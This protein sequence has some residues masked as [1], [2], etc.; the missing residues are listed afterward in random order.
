MSEIS[1]DKKERVTVVTRN[2]EISSDS[3]SLREKIPLG[4]KSRFFMETERPD[5][6]SDSSCFSWN[7]P[8][9]TTTAR[10]LAS[11]LPEYNFVE[12][13]SLTVR[14]VENGAKFV[15]GGLPKIELICSP[16]PCIIVAH[17]PFRSTLTSRRVL[18]LLV[19][20]SAQHALS[21]A[22]LFIECGLWEGAVCKLEI[23]RPSGGLLAR[24][25]RDVWFVASCFHGKTF[26]LFR[27]FSLRLF[28]SSTIPHIASNGCNCIML[29]SFLR[30][31]VVCLILHWLH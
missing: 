18:S 9:S 3:Q 15:I 21:S 31:E 1:S 19:W 17:Q 24:R 2:S 28:S 8:V 10:L 12:T 7:V 22:G 6:G 26:Y 16:D 13:S 23:I 29:S 5:F 27:T 4:I 25:Q 30:A 20:V 14:Q 11:P